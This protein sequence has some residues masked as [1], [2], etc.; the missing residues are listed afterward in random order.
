MEKGLEHKSC[1]QWLR[2]LGLFSLEKEGVA[3]WGVA[4]S[5]KQSLTGQKD[6]VL[7]CV[8]GGLY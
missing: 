7:N 8:S 5:H 3:R 2:V 4:S 6:R 1:E